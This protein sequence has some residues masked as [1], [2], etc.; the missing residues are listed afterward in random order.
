MANYYNDIETSKLVNSPQFTETFNTVY[1]IEGEV[2]EEKLLDLGVYIQDNV[3]MKDYTMNVDG[4]ADVVQW[5]MTVDKIVGQDKY[6]VKPRGIAI[7]MDLA[8]LIQDGSTAYGYD[9]DDY[10]NKSIL[11]NML[12]YAEEVGEAID[13]NKR[14]AR[15]VIDKYG[16]SSY[17]YRL[18]DIV[19]NYFEQFPNIDN[20]YTVIQ[21][22]IPT[23]ENFITVYDHTDFINNQAGSNEDGALTSTFT[24]RQLK[25]ALDYLNENDSDF[26]SIMSNSQVI[27]IGY[28]QVSPNIT[29]MYVNGYT[30]DNAKIVTSN[31]SDNNQHYSGLVTH[32]K[33]A[34]WATNPSGYGDRN[35]HR[36]GGPW[37]AN[38]SVSTMFYNYPRSA[39]LTQQGLTDGGVINANGMTV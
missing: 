35:F 1:Y 33:G 10:T 26:A 14:I 20:P 3:L 5:R 16:R 18:M 22:P 27:R 2:T 4:N 21:K 7:D 23:G 15:G 24:P 12:S 11:D 29:R 31:E 30:L 19:N 17:D 36:E 13:V 25:E 9:I 8:K 32:V 34:M 39:W 28:N 37:D 6:E 38:K